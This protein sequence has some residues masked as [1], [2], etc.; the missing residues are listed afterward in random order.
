MNAST[1]SIAPG[2]AYR[3]KA[4]VPLAPNVELGDYTDLSVERPVFTVTDAD[5]DAQIERL[6][7]EHARVVPVSDRS[8]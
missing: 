1:R 5:V 6:R 7:T 2:E 8:I 3:F 4:N